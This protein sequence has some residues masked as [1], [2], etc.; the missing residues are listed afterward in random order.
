MVPKS[1]WFSIL[2]HGLMNQ[3]IQGYNHD[4]WT[5]GTLHIH[6]GCSVAGDPGRLLSH[7]SAL[8]TRKSGDPSRAN[9]ERFFSPEIE[10]RFIATPGRRW[11][12]EEKLHYIDG[13]LLFDLCLFGDFF[14]LIQHG[15]LMVQKCRE[16]TCGLNEIMII[17]QGCST[18]GIACG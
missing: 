8:A 5:L 18:V 9:M 15:N 7:P 14:F 11:Q 17:H 12:R 1:P 2:K 13:D 10:L 3:M 16:Q 6:S 4:L